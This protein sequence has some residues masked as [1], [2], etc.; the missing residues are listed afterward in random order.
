MMVMMMF[1]FSTSISNVLSRLSNVRLVKIMMMMTAMLT[2]ITMIVMITK[3][4]N[5]LSAKASPAPVG[6][7]VKTRR[8]AES[9]MRLRWEGGGFRI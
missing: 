5:R 9:L 8:V 1:F 6:P 2:L 7:S 4:N 3:Y